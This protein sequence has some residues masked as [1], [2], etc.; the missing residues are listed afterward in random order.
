MKPFVNKILNNFYL[1]NLFLVLVLTSVHL[2]SR[3][4]SRDFNITDLPISYMFA[5]WSY[6]MY[7]FHNMFLYEK[8]LKRKKYFLYLLLFVALL[9]VHRQGYNELMG[10]FQKLWLRLTYR[11]WLALH[12]LDVMYF[13][14][15][16][17][18]YL[19]FT[20]SRERE[21]LLL[22]ENEKKELELKHL[23]QQL[24]PHFLFNALNG[25]Y[26]YLITNSSDGRELVLKLSELMRY[27]LDSSKK[28]LV[29]LQ[30][31]IVFIENYLAFSAERLGDRCTIQYNKTGKNG[32]ARIVPLILFTFIENAFKHGA[33]T[34]AHSLITIDLYA[35]NSV[36]K[37]KVTNPVNQ[38][39]Q[40]STHTGLENTYRRLDLLYP[41]QHKLET[42]TMNGI[43]IAELEINKLS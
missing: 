27:I 21:R 1:R 15:A 37:L 26:S 31:E 39:Q 17:G 11:G 12:W 19:A 10:H 8:V 18:V 30:D 40:P 36:L 3:S 7:M 35:G 41:G 20:Y 9:I 29:P 25:I 16:L 13:M 22:V 38:P 43:Y 34:I 6:T 33:T 5:A 2:G 32:D 28:E 42:R 23:N 14:L 4:T 24:N